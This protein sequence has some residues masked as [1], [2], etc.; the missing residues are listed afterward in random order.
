MPARILPASQRASEFG[1]YKEARQARKQANNWL[2]SGFPCWKLVSRIR[3]EAR[4]LA[5]TCC[6]CCCFVRS[7]ALV[8]LQLGWPLTSLI[9]S[10]AAATIKSSGPIRSGR[11]LLLPAKRRPRQLITPSIVGLIVCVCEQQ[12][13]L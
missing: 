7:T 12:L 6:Y 5:S 11:L 2:E 3:R 1:Q 10:L 4:L 9:A 13:R 8:C